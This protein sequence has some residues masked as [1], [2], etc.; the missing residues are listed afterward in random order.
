MPIPVKER[1]GLPGPPVNCSWAGPAA[2]DLLAPGTTAAPGIGRLPPNLIQGITTNSSLR[3]ARL[4]PH[5]ATS[6]HT[7]KRAGWEMIPT[8]SRC[9]ARGTGQVRGDGAFLG[10]AEPWQRATLGATSAAIP[11]KAPRT[12]RLSQG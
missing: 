3:W 2:Q 10:V 1:T 11:G 5:L 6:L 7:Q 8:C 9:S 12:A 4:C